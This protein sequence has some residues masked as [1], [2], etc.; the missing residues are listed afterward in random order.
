MSRITY[1]GLEAHKDSIFVAMLVPGRKDVVQWEMPN[2]PMAA[3]K[4]AQARQQ[5][6][7]ESQPR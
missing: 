6:R 3:R 5:G 2:G 1:V 4:L 7:L